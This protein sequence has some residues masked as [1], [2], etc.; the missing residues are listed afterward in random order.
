MKAINKIMIAVLAIAVLVGNNIYAYG[1]EKTLKDYQKRT[2][3]DIN[4]INKATDGALGV[5]DYALTAAV[6]AGSVGALWAIHTRLLKN[7]ADKKI[8]IEESYL[9]KALEAREAALKIA[10]AKTTKLSAVEASRKLAEKAKQNA[11]G[12]L[13][14]ERAALNIAKERLS[15][16]YEANL[17][18]GAAYIYAYKTQNTALVRYLDVD[19]PGRIYAN[20]ESF[21]LGE[22]I[23]VLSADPKTAASAKELKTLLE[24]LPKDASDIP[25]EYYVKK[26]VIYQRLR[27]SPKAPRLKF[28]LEESI[29]KEDLPF[30][31]SASKDMPKFLESVRDFEAKGQTTLA[32]QVIENAVREEPALARVLPKTFKRF[33][34]VATLF[35]GAFLVHGSAMAQGRVQKLRVNPSLFLKADTDTLAVAQKD[36]ELC[37]SLILMSNAVHE[38]SLMSKTD[39]KKFLAAVVSDQQLKKRQINLSVPPKRTI[40]FAKYGSL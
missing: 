31:L 9:R 11:E 15:K 4:K 32:R 8:K 40:D 35:A 12:Q 18:Q 28:W 14:Q 17:L 26:A 13:L 10:D 25:A 39:M 38:I 29:V 2:Q 34:V 24:S 21:E 33:G 30:I 7:A 37:D 5:G 22:N 1:A 19:G 27:L 23:K 36:K 3:E 6:A 20:I 16:A